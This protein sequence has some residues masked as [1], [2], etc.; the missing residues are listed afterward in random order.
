M[1][2]L[3][4]AAVIDLTIALENDGFVHSVMAFYF[5]SGEPI[6]EEWPWFGHQLS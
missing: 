4:F 5:V 1:S 6:P 2:I 3:T